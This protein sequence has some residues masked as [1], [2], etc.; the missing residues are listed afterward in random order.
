[1]SNAEAKS[2]R[3]KTPWP[4]AG[5][6]VYLQFKTSD[7]EALQLEFGDEWFVLAKDRL[8]RFDI[9]F[10]RKVA[11]IGGKK[12]GLPHPV[13]LDDVEETMAET[14]E[15]LLNSLF[16]AMHGKTFLQYMGWLYERMEEERV[17]MES[18]KK[19]GSDDP[20]RKG[21]ADSSDA[22]GQQPQEQA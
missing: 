2:L 21:P 14:A 20:S 18:G 10:M 4:A 9:P 12:D 15:T 22:S 8:Q 13:D 7:M 1:M 11:A 19:K 3:G 5:H 16:M 6:G 17:E